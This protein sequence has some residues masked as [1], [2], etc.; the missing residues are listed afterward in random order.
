MNELSETE[1]VAQAKKEYK[2]KST[3]VEYVSTSQDFENKILCIFKVKK[4]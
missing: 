3:K 2:A 4:W 1:R